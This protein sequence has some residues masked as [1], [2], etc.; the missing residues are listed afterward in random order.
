MLLD[1][2]C[3]VG[4]KMKNKGMKLKYC[5]KDKG[6]LVALSVEPFYFD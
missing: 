6:A 3:L 1:H 2:V 4:W 5:F